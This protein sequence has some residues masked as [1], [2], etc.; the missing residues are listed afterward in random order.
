MAMEARLLIPPSI[1]DL[2]RDADEENVPQA[3]SS[4]TPEVVSLGGG[5]V[6]CCD[7]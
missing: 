2:R 7:S 3:D 5:R 6:G 4:W 1:D